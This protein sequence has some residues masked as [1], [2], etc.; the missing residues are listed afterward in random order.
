MSPQTAK[1]DIFS[2]AEIDAFAPIMKIGL[3][4]TITPEGLPHITLLSSLKAASEKTLTWGQ[5][6]EGMSFHNVRANPKIGWLIMTLNKDLWRGTGRFTHTA[7]SGEDFDWYNDVP[8]F[9]YN[10]YFGIHTV[11]YMDLIEHTGLQPLPMGA[12][13]MAAIKTMFAKRFFLRKD[14]PVL[15]AWTKGLFNKLDGLKFLAYID[16]AGF[17]KLVP[18]IQAQSAGNQHILFSTGAFTAEIKAIPRDTPMAVFGMSL[19]MTDVL[20]RGTYHGLRLVGPHRCG[21]LE[22]DWVYN[23]MP[24]VPGQI[25]PPVDLSPVREFDAPRRS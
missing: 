14:T 16:D 23:P 18:V 19:D 4:A 6:T 8:M 10:A 5:F 3:L 22:V 9:R 17:P 25:Y 24:P 2:Q 21:V 12:V 7:A 20:V 13:V 15:N 1:H 11:Y